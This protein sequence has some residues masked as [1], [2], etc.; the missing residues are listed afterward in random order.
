MLIPE[1]RAH[2]GFYWMQIGRQA[3]IGFW[4]RRDVCLDFEREG[5]DCRQ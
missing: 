2:F 1:N 3:V 4:Q 5:A